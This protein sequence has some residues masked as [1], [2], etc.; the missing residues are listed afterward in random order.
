LPWPWASAVG[1]LS[2][3]EGV[4]VGD[5][6]ISGFSP[7]DF[8]A[9]ESTRFNTA[10]PMPNL[11][12]LATATRSGTP[13]TPAVDLIGITGGTNTAFDRGVLYVRDLLFNGSLFTGP[14]QGANLPAPPNVDYSPGDLRL[15][16]DIAP[17][18]SAAT[19]PLSPVVPG[20]GGSRNPLVDRGFNGPLPATM[21]NGRVLTLAP[22]KKWPSVGPG[23]EFKHWF[24]SSWD[25]DC[26]G[27]GNPRIFDHPSYNPVNPSRNPS[28]PESGLIDIG[29]DELGVNIIAG[30]RFGTTTFMSFE[31]PYYT[32]AVQNKFAWFLGPANSSGAPIPGEYPRYTDGFPLSNMLPH[33]ASW[34]YNPPS[35]YYQPTI[36]DIAPHLLPDI[37]PWW[38]QWFA[39]AA[40]NPIWHHGGC[41]TPQFYNPSLFYFPSEGHVNPPG[42]RGNGNPPGG[43]FYWLEEQHPIT[44]VALGNKALTK[45]AGGSN[46]F[47]PAPN[48][49]G[50]GGPGVIIQFGAWCQNTIGVPGFT[51][52]ETWLPTFPYNPTQQAPPF[53]AYRYSTEYRIQRPPP[54]G[55]AGAPTIGN[56]ANLQ[57]FMV[58]VE[59]RSGQ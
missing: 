36:V 53:T 25:T 48:G 30:Y 54:F 55:T 1:P 33:V 50:S 26:E 18:T 44:L 47:D 57:S 39:G 34:D 5:V 15:A 56:G 59:A 19:G 10:V 11:G 4:D 27:F 42:S 51:D 13:F 40:T 29:A 35:G 31:R 41:G 17:G 3:F 46:N 14:F 16:P 20:T 28:F 12:L 37:H 32:F 21:T 58:L 23:S 43:S 8:N 24:F 52:H 6:T 7:G 2:C 9:Y 22:G 38:Q 49:G 45:G